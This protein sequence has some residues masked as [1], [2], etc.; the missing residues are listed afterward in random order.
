MTTQQIIA[1]HGVHPPSWR[2]IA[3]ILLFVALLPIA[4]PASCALYI[5]FVPAHSASFHIAE[6][7]TTVELSFYWVWG[8]RADNSGRYFRIRSPRGTTSHEMCGFDWAHGART[9]VYLTDE[10]KIAIQGFHEC[11]DF[12][13]PDLVVTQNLPLRS[14][15]WR[16]LGAFDL[17]YLSA[18]AGARHMRFIPAS[19]QAECIVMGGSDFVRDWMLRKEAR[20]PGCP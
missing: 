2:R 14:E 1:P 8:E 6:I 7:D 17:V 5:N 9:G 3:R 11:L 12:V 10:R 20:K 19:E 16:Y 15:E 4:L 13:S 18:G